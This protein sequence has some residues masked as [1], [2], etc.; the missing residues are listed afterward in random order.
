M[1]LSPSDVLRGYHILSIMP[2]TPPFRDPDFHTF[3]ILFL[4]HHSKIKTAHGGGQG[5]AK[6]TES[7]SKV[8][9]MELKWRPGTLLKVV[10]SADRFGK[11]LMCD[12]YI[13]CYVFVT[14]APPETHHF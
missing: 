13:I 10:F 11:G 7:V 1:L 2:P 12:P 8:F 5:G 9:K 6:T 3:F 4:L 14:L